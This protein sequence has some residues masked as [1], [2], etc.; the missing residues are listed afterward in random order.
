[1]NVI[2][3]IE[4]LVLHGFPAGDR[5]AIAEALTRELSRLVAER[6]VPDAAP[7]EPRSMKMDAAPWREASPW[8]CVPGQAPASD[9]DGRRTLVR[10][11][12]ASVFSGQMPHAASAAPGPMKM[13]VAACCVPGQAPASGFSGQFVLSPS[14]RGEAV[15]VAA[16]R[17]VMQVVEAV[18][19]GDCF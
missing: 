3:E 6:L 17:A 15:G 11:A 16:G 12:P 7:A 19:A 8:D 4:E 18:L 1:M 10:N 13:D 14:A 2:I 5:Y 9:P